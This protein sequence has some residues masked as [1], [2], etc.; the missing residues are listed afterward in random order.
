MKKSYKKGIKKYLFSEIAVTVI[1]ICV[2]ALISIPLA[3]N[4]SKQYK[5]N[6]EIRDLEAEIGRL[7]SKNTELY[8]LIDYLES[9]QFVDEQAR[10]NLNFKSPDEE[11]YIIKQDNS[12]RPAVD[13]TELKYD[14]G[15]GRDAAQARS[16]PQ[17]WLDYF[18]SGQN[19]N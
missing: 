9:D 6:Q 4:I 3:R 10:L 14:I 11:V 18:F 7:E 5:I 17:K 2:L 16:N 1:G 15:T 8:K 19:L 12:G 13:N